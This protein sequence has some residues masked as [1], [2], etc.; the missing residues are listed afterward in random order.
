MHAD[1][2]VQASSGGNH[3]KAGVES[4]RAAFNRCGAHQKSPPGSPCRGWQSPPPAPPASPSEPGLECR[5]RVWC[6]SVCAAAAASAATAASG[7]CSACSNSLQGG[8]TRMRI[9]E[10]RLSTQCCFG[11]GSIPCPHSPLP[12]AEPRAG[13][14]EPLIWRGGCAQLSGGAGCCGGCSGPTWL[15]KC[16]AS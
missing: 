2:R 3:R 13:C 15:E 14:V 7:R 1:A 6:V 16:P 10:G 8:A 5:A 11:A 9:P 12:E 4:A